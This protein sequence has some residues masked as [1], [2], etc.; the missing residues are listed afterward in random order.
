MKI[1]II[2]DDHLSIFLSR[3]MLAI[4]DATLDIKTFLSGAEALEVLFASDEDNIPEV[5]FVDLNMPIMDGWGL[6]D[7]LS[8]LEYRLREKCSI[9][10]LTSSL[11]TSDTDRLQNYPFVSG[12][13]HKPI[14]SE[15]IELIFSFQ[16]SQSKSLVL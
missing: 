15:D 1:F 9:Y 4:E 6:L 8:P 2:D 7:A 16:R 10:I 12:L 14:K 5:M 11:D 3:N 13:I